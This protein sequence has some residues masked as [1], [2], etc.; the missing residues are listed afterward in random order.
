[1]PGFQAPAGHAPA[2]ADERL[3][4]QRLA[5][6]AQQMGDYTATDRPDFDHE[7]KLQFSGLKDSEYIRRGLARATRHY[8]SNGQPEEDKFVLPV[9]ELYKVFTPKELASKQCSSVGI[10]VAR[11]VLASVPEELGEWFESQD[12]MTFHLPAQGEETD[13]AHAIESALEAW[14]NV[15]SAK[16]RAAM[17]AKA[18]DKRGATGGRP[19][20]AAP[21][22]PPEPPS[23]KSKRLRSKC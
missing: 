7:P 23:K 15:S 18:A 11:H 4:E 10:S 5:A 14:A 21:S 1:M 12:S 17:R 20:K 2:D 13:A 16:L 19:A 9:R 8:D 6:A 3:L 22:E